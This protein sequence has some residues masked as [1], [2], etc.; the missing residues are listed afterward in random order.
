MTSSSIKKIDTKITGFAVKTAEA[1]PAQPITEAPKVADLNVVQMN[2]TVGRPEM[3][4]GATYKVKIPTEEHAMYVTINDTIL[5]HG[6]EYEERRPFEIFINSKN[7]TNFQWVVALTRLCS[8]V[9]RK[10]GDSTFMVE[11]LMAVFDP[12]GGYFKPG[13]VFMPSVVAE[14]GF[15]LKKHM[16]MLGMIPVDELDEHQK[17]YIE[18]KKQEL[19]SGE[20]GGEAFPSH[21]TLCNKCSTKAVIV[22][23]GCAC[24]LQ[25]G[26]SA[27]G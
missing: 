9:F 7:M 20:T 1:E 26:D 8:A 15:V 11:E 17:A 13:G 19:V 16:Q 25:C 27:C 6:T 4:V 5:N 23:D 22:K 21:A 3:L 12:K 2:E 14:I 24:C 10:G 18:S